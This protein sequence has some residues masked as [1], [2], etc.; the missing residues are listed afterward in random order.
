M[1]AAEASL[2]RLGTDRLDFYFVHAFDDHSP[3]KQTLRAL[4]DL[5]RQGKILCPA[6]SNW[7]A[8]QIATALGTQDREGLS[9]FELVQPMYNLA[10]RKPRSRSCPSHGPSGWA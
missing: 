5:V 7:A 1:S 3:I 6:V 2:R 10:R 4:D 9:R 8:W